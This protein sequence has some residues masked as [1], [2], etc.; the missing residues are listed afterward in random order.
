MQ[1]KDRLMKDAMSSIPEPFTAGDVATR[2]AQISKWALNARQCAGLIRAY[3]L[4]DQVGISTNPD[5]RGALYVR[6]FI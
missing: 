2:M 3:G 1:R 4:A 5:N 6:R